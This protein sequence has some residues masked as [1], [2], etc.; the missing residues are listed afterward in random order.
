MC[1]C[2]FSHV[3]LFVMLWMKPTRLL[4]PPDS[5]GKNTGVS[6]HDALQEIHPPSPNSPALANRLFTIS[7]TFEAQ[8]TYDA[9]FKMHPGC[10]QDKVAISQH[11]KHRPSIILFI[12]INS[13]HTLTHI[14]CPSHTRILETY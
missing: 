9:L 8:T 10:L 4:R 5:P 14:L 13:I 7:T 2:Y 11:R 6:C 3:Q 12:I 1:M